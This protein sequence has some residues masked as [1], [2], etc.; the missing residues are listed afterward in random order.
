MGKLPESDQA[1]RL[2]RAES[3][4]EAAEKYQLKR[5]KML[6]SPV[7]LANVLA[8]H[9]I[10]PDHAR[11]VLDSGNRALVQSAR[12]SVETALTECREALAEAVYVNTGCDERFLVDGLVAEL[13]SIAALLDAMIE[14]TPEH[15]TAAVLSALHQI[16]A[17][18][19]G[20][21]SADA[22]MAEA[23]HEALV[24]E[25][26]RIRRYKTLGTVLTVGSSNGFKMRKSERLAFDRRTG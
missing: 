1:R 4:L 8:R 25:A 10:A 9:R 24:Q 3:R 14:T 26:E 22:W 15:Q 6:E 19:A 12:E 7:A 2:R 13:S 21:T 18:H 11:R 16:I 17:R 23:Q 20:A 5:R